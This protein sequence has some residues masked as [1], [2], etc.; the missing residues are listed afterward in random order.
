[1][2]VDHVDAGCGGDRSSGGYAKLLLPRPPVRRL[3][4][5]AAVVGELAPGAAQ[6]DGHAVHAVLGEAVGAHLGL[7]ACGALV[8][9]LGGHD[10]QGGEQAP[11]Q[12]KQGR[13][14]RL[15]VGKSKVGCRCSSSQDKQSIL[16]APQRP[17]FFCCTGRSVMGD[18]LIYGNLCTINPCPPSVTHWSRLLRYPRTPLCA[19]H[20][21]SAQPD[22]PF[23][24]IPRPCTASTL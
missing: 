17:L 3:A 13:G 15:S 22:T 21:S 6:R 24:S 8:L 12:Q 16:S 9:F 20:P 2:R 23:R 1:M 5:P 7:G 14:Q 18:E 19:R 10:E 11:V 4:G